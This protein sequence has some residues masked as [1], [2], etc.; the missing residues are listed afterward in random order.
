[1]GQERYAP[2][3]KKQHMARGA[4]ILTERVYNISRIRTLRYTTVTKVKQVWTSVRMRKSTSS[5][6]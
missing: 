4:G 3:R 2:S 5:D 1:L 6:V